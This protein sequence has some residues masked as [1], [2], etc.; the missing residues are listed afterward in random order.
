MCRNPQPA[1]AGTRIPTWKYEAVRAG[2]LDILSDAGEQGVLLKD[3]KP[4]LRAQLSPEILAK[5]GSLGWHMMTVKLE[6]EAAGD[7]TRVQGPGP[8]KLMIVTT[9]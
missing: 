1:K 3:L 4:A 9:A 5:I 7:I 2:I 6:M 8:Q